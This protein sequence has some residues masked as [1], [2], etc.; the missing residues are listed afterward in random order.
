MRGKDVTAGC[1]CQHLRAPE[2]LPCLSVPV[3]ATKETWQGHSRPHA[4]YWQCQ[5]DKPLRLA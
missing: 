5:G 3:Q 1:G 4:G 2:L